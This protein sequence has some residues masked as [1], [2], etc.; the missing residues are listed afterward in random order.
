MNQLALF[1]ILHN[2]AE[3]IIQNNDSITRTSLKNGSKYDKDEVEAA[4]S[5][6][7]K[8][9]LLTPLKSGYVDITKGKS[10]KDFVPKENIFYPIV[11]KCIEKLWFASRYEPGEFFLSNTSSGNPP[12]F[13][14]VYQ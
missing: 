2:I 6:G 5:I 10:I 4:I 3:R 9:G 14:G 1:D 12:I 11:E 13:N 8:D 7:I